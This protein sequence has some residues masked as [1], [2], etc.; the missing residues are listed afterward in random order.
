MFS[1]KDFE[2]EV[3]LFKT[4]NKGVDGLGFAHLHLKDCGLIDESSESDIVVYINL[5][6]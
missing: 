2:E 3:N 5:D 6:E 1:L 4:K